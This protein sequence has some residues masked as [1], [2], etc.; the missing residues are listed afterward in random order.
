[1]SNDT[2]DN[3]SWLILV[4]HFPPEYFERVAKWALDHL[5]QASLGVRK[6]LEKT[7]R[8]EVHLKGFADA[9]KAITG[10]RP[11]LTARLVE[12]ADHSA[13][14]C[15][16]V[17]TVWAESQEKLRGDVRAFLEGR[18]EEILDDASAWESLSNVWW[19]EE[20][21]EVR[22]AFQEES[23]GY[24]ENDAALML[25][26]L[27]GRFPLKRPAEETA[28][29]D[30]DDV[31]MD[32]DAVWVKRMER[33][34]ASTEFTPSQSAAAA[35]M[36]AW[37]SHL[38]ALPVDAPEWDLVPAFADAMVEMLTS[39]RE[40][41][42]ARAELACALKTLCVEWKDELEWWGIDSSQWS[43]STVSAAALE[44]IKPC[45]DALPRILADYAALRDQVT[46][47]RQQE[48]ER[49]KKME[50]KESGIE[51]LFEGLQSV[52]GGS[53]LPPGPDSGPDGIDR[54]EQKDRSDELNAETPGL[55]S[56]VPT[57]G[58][59]TARVAVGG[60]TQT[61]EPTAALF[62]TPESEEDT[63][64]GAPMLSDEA[65]VA[66]VDVIEPEEQEITAI[67]GQTQGLPI[68][69]SENALAPQG[70]ALPISI[71]DE[72]EVK[73]GEESARNM[74]PSM[75]AIEE[76]VLPESAEQR[77]RDELQEHV[78]QPTESGPKAAGAEYNSLFWSQIAQGDLAGAYWLARSLE[79]QG[80]TAPAPDWLV[81]ALQASQW[82]TYETPDL[83]QELAKIVESN[84]LS[85]DPTHHMLA[86][87]AALNPALIE[88][89]SQMM[90]WLEASS[91]CAELRSLIMAVKSFAALGIALQPGDASAVANVQQRDDNVGAAA[92][93]VKRW[94]DEA[95]RRRKRANLVWGALLGARGELRNFLAPIADDRRRDLASVQK[96]LQRWQQHGYADGLIDQINQTFSNVTTDRVT[97]AP[98]QE[99]H[100]E[101][102]DAVALVKRWCELVERA[103]QIE[104]RGN[105]YQLQVM[106][107][108]SHAE[109]AL[110]GVEVWLSELVEEGQTGGEAVAARCLVIA[111][112]ELRQLLDLPLGEPELALAERAPE[113][114]ALPRA[115]VALHSSLNRRLLWLP[116]L[117][118][119]SD[120]SPLVEQLPEIGPALLTAASE[121]RTLLSAARAWLDRQ[122]YRFADELITVLNAQAQT[123]DFLQDYQDALS[124]SRAALR[125]VIAETESAIEQAL[126]DGV[127]A[128]EDRSRY[129]ASFASLSLEDVRNFRA[130][131]AEMA[132]IRLALEEQRQERLAHL[133]ECWAELEERLGTSHI[134]QE[135]Q[136]EA[137]SVLRSR[138]DLGDTR[139]VDECLARLS[140]ALDS[141]EDLPTDWYAPADGRDYLEEF[142]RAAP[143][144]ERW[145]GHNYGDLKAAEVAVRDGQTIADIK[146]GDLPSSRRKEAMEAFVAWRTLKQHSAKANNGALIATILEYLAFELKTPGAT[147]IE[148]LQLGS[149]W[150]HARAA[151]SAGALARPIPEFGSQAPAQL[152][153][154]CLWERPGADAIAAL[155]HDLKLYTHTVIV[156]Y[157]GR[158]TVSQRREVIRVSRDRELAI[159]VLD[160]TLL[161]FLAQ[162]RDARLPGFLR[163]ALPFSALNPYRPFQAGDVPPEMFFGR[164]AM[165]RELQRPAGSCMVYGG[166]Q[167]GKSA[168]LRHVQRQFHHPDRQQY[169][170]VEAMNLVFDPA[171]GRGTQQVWRALR[172][173]MKREGLLAPA[174]RTDRPEGIAEHIREALKADPRRRVLVMLD[175]ADDFLD[176]DAR[177]GF[178]EVAV[179]R[180]L[181]LSTSRRFKVVFAGLHNVQRF[182]G[183]PN[184]PLA[185]FG[186]PLCVGPLEASA[187]QQLVRQPLEVVGYRF[188]DEASVLRVLSYTNYHP[189]LIQYYCQELLKQLRESSTTAAPPYRILQSDVEAIYRSPYVRDRIRERF[190][191]TLALDTHYQAIAW[192]LIEDQMKIRDS[193]SQAY[194]PGE[195]LRMAR[196]WWP[197][198][199][200]QVT[201]GQLRGWL[202]E[203]CGLGVLVRN[204]AG[205]YRLRSPNVVR[206]L[207]KEDDI[208]YRLLELAQRPPVDVFDGD[209]HH[210]PLDDAAIRYSPLTYAQERSLT[211]P[212]AGVGLVFASEAL[213]LRLLPD[214]VRRF[215]PADL[216]T[217]SGVASEIPGL[218]QNE[219][220]LVE[221]LTTYLKAQAR[222]ERLVVYL[223]SGSFEAQ[224][225]TSLVRA[226]H[227]FCARHQV[228][229]RWLRV[230]FLLDPEA[231][232]NWLSLPHDIRTS[233]EDACDAALAP[234]RW[235]LS[236]IR[237]RLA[238]HERIYRDD[239]C[240]EVQRVTGG[241]PFLL[242]VLFQKSGR[243]M[244]VRPVCQVLEAEFV[245]PA[246]GLQQRFRDSLGLSR[247]QTATRVLQFVAREGQ[248]P[249]ELLTPDM[250]GDRP[251]LSTTECERACEY[252]TRLSVMDLRGDLLTVDALVARALA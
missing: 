170:W 249:V 213:G 167:L 61:Q 47:T 103:Q 182:Q 79:I 248:V 91:C 181:M 78:A 247:N 134:S 200:V 136:N 40:A 5:G 171:A 105:W 31:Q 62:F 71:E 189:G 226:S 176:A 55:L 66:N 229:N 22:S 172:D 102:D 32:G 125:N 64:G 45:I 148:T 186:V 223:R 123:T 74:G 94:L 43:V 203:M 52:L 93:A 39:K 101:I 183:I 157:L 6:R 150:L 140:E 24:D 164:E 241:W 161:V 77:A 15:R 143:Q 141:G 239:V 88:P 135:K 10:A 204:T 19:L 211:Q 80:L 13:E 214:A 222:T 69:A 75:P 73:A 224:Q 196:E 8:A 30:D 16:A 210:A 144:I 54:K 195:L 180:E 60:E 237:R 25:C 118:L 51:V 110:P 21:E 100:R 95:P 11:L 244:D 86:L 192:T 14:I 70:T 142:N 217:D 187:A 115:G 107:L 119:M 50:E 151:V 130:K 154:V 124:G 147:A 57:S 85:S 2:L 178:H 194:P 65:V 220:H 175:E 212:R 126:V 128:E 42:A 113:W 116:E 96:D 58:Q 1:M 109:D 41:A 243:Q 185:H 7:I 149:D 166:R 234:G 232:W 67:Q 165:A 191:W 44:I 168:L 104:S 240:S 36:G 138:L 159:A 218:L 158:L 184:Q 139:V 207:G 137:R 106:E 146:L 28:D 17:L 133:I 156:L 37:L 33:E 27:T 121:N 245:D 35:R 48:Q 46:A 177:D 238:Q 246:S 90:A 18:S 131:F 98:R 227:E 236:A 251:D 12:A 198:G 127:I 112:K 83:A 59:A 193:Y 155:L 4:H 152:D 114:L 216:L 230:V 242:D 53:P 81:A 179:L 56:D 92:R 38:E 29:K 82:L 162:E 221:W 84:E 76:F 233:L 120:C 68:E 153:V 89:S 188:V 219:H 209:S 122:D 235:S 87:A 63:A 20:L 72:S 132:D 252:L 108:R 117:T 3:A 190:D 23:E 34:F 201:S 231:T 26:L 49:R 225:L 169:A 99:L 202:D 160:E 9:S 97:G 129:N 111:V 215:I 250:I 173:A 208:S 145:L 174:V 199:F 205:H 228:T 197:A 206:L 163:C